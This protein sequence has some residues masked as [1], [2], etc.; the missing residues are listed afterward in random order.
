LKRLGDDA[1]PDKMLELWTRL[2]DICLDHLG[3]TEAATEAYQVACELA[4]DDVARHEQLADLYLEAGEARRDE[5]IVELQYLLGH[6]PDRVELYKALGSLYRA[7]H[8]LDKAFCV[9]QALVFLGAASDEEKGLYQRLRPTQFTPAPR[10]LT[11]EL[12][13][14][15]IIHPK[16][17]RHV[18]A[19]FSST[20]GALAA[21]TAQPIS[22]F[23][24]T[25]ET[26]TDL[27]RDPRTVSRIV[28]Y[29][30]GVL[31][32]DPAPM[33]WLQEGGDGLRVANTVGLGAE[34]QRLVPSL[35]IGAPQIGKNDERELAFEV[36]K[37]MAYLRPERF[38]TLA[39]GTLPKLEAA[40][41][42]SV[43]AGGA[44]VQNHDGTSFIEHT[45]EEARKLAG[46]L[47][48]QVP[49]PLLEQVGELST[50]LSNRLGNGLIS[51]WRTATDLTANRVGLIVSN[52]LETAAKAIA[53]EGAAMSNLSVKDRLRDLLAYSVSEQYFLVR[54]HLGLHVRGEATA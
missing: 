6:A 2:G 34:R 36:G 25:A 19:I 27:D 26:R 24:L 31:A 44:R 8:E 21:G 53:T 12:W 13:Q 41:A 46:T 35:L 5:A 42:A 4:P 23:G 37:R 29:V 28:K 18:G 15:S 9:A 38:V 20:L 17:D 45:S 51:G 48:S 1:S 22:A 32:I 14:K 52:D 49:G 16:E 40:F 30:S 7:E 50:K 47:K 43:L 33:V 39:V 10:R 3:D 11:E 54:R